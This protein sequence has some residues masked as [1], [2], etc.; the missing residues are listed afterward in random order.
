MHASFM[1]HS[2]IQQW[3]RLWIGHILN[4]SLLTFI[5]QSESSFLLLLNNIWLLNI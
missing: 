4:I 2:F 5:L 3:K 1:P